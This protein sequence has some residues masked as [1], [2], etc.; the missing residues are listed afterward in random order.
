MSTT[1]YWRFLF[2]GGQ[3]LIFG[4]M[5]LI[6]FL[7]TKSWLGL[8]FT[9][10]M[11]TALF[12]ML[13]DRVYDSILKRKRSPK[14]FEFILNLSWLFLL[15]WWVFFYGKFE[16]VYWAIDFY[17]WSVFTLYMGILLSFLSMLFAAHNLT[18]T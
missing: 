9:L 7:S 6:N 13:T 4:N 18:R 12:F 8:F 11:S 5:A 2:W 14:L 16:Q 15:I 17:Y 3:A 1:K 10:L